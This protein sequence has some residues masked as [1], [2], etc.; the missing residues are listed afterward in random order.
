MYLN[1]NTSFNLSRD[2]TEGRSKRF[3]DGLQSHIHYHYDSEQ[4]K[5]KNS[6][7]WAHVRI[8][9]DYVA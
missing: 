4:T 1:R 8:N 2:L 6:N 9:S 7:K 5:V 3:L